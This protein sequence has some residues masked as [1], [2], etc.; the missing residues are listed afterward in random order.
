MTRSLLLLLSALFSCFV[1]AQPDIQWQKAYGGTAAESVVDIKPTGDGGCIFIA[2]TTSTDG[3]VTD[4][5]LFTDIW[6]VKVKASGAIDWKK[7]YGGDSID[8]GYTIEPAGDGGY[9]FAGYTRSVNG[10]VTGNTGGSNK[11]WI[12]K[13]NA[14]GAITW[15]K[16]FDS[17]AYIQDIIAV[18]DG[19]VFVST[20]YSSGVSTDI[21]V[22][23]IDNTGNE[24]WQ[25]KYGGTLNDNCQ[26]IRKTPDGG[27]I[28]CG[29]SNSKDGDIPKNMGS[30]DIC[31]MKL[32]DTGKLVMQVSLG[33]SKNDY[34]ASA[35]PSLYGGYILTGYTMSNDSNVTGYRDS[36]DIWVVKIGETGNIEWQKPIGGI[37]TDYG[38][39]V[40]QATNGNYILA[41]YS[42]STDG[43]AV[44]NHG[45]GDML[46]VGLYP[47]GSFRWKKVMGSS[48][49]DGAYGI[50][51]T[52]D[53]GFIVGGSVAA[54][55]G[56]A[57]GSGFHPGTGY[58]YDC[59]LVKLSS[60]AGI[61]EI[62]IPGEIKVYPTVTAGTVFL[63]LPAGYEKA[64][65][66]VFSATGQKIE[67]TETGDPLDRVIQ[68]GNIPA[69]NYLLQVY[70]K[71]EV[72][73]QKIVHQQ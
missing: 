6:V 26:S 22:V 25:K 70:N 54:A 52:S 20:S 1:Y 39:Q 60:V 56:D 30:A 47:D 10:D 36:T 11:G 8:Y 29:S 19:Y 69:G 3:D 9:V 59:W 53:G 12:V 73:T 67:V 62:P 33:G 23:K 32:D 17:I 57:T 13:I 2:G 72:Y 27:Y 16:L 49:T 37:R 5:H 7:C 45:L 15:Q 58:S 21:Q 42:L 18:N 38:Y 50:V 41:A 43:D 31:I 4:S 61:G 63:S 51:Q 71:G 65:I 68:L 28:I 64:D 35:C 66:K 48:L 14:T 24:V 44:G 46:V 55:D 40:I 34:G